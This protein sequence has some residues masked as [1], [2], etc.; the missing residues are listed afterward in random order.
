LRRRNSKDS[1]KEEGTTLSPA[2]AH[3]IV[4]KKKKKPFIQMELI[5]II[6]VLASGWA[7]LAVSVYSFN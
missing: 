1:R 5:K 3:A 7:T 6:F 2:V 4:K